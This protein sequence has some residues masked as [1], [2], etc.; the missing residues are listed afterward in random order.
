MASSQPHSRRLQILLLAAAALPPLA[1]YLI[2]FREMLPIPILDDYHAILS[3]ALDFVHLPSVAAKLAWVIHAQHNGY[4]LVFE[5]A[6]VAAQIVLLHRLDFGVLTTLGNLTLLPL[7]YALWRIYFRTESDR[8]TRLI[9]FLPV[10]CLLFAI[11]YAENLDY[12]MTS[13]QNLPVVTFAFLAVF[14]FAEPGVRR[15][16]LACLCAV[17]AVACSGNGLMLAPVVGLMLLM[18]RRVR[19]LAVA[20]VLFSALAALYLRQFQPDTTAGPSTLPGKIGYLLS[21]AGGAVENMH[22]W[23]VSGLAIAVGAVL[24]AVFLHAA[25]Q[26]FDRSEPAAFYSTLWVLITAAAVTMARAGYQIPQSLSSRYKIYSD[27]LLIFGYAYLAERLRGKLSPARRRQ[28]QAAVLAVCVIFTAAS[29]ALAY[30]FLHKRRLLTLERIEA[31]RQNPV[32]NSPQIDIL[33]PQFAQAIEDDQEYA[34]KMM[35]QAVAAGL[36]RLPPVKP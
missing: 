15:G 34:R 9:L 22:R 33:N 1:A 14:L 13:L 26:R 16:I 20:V 17:L 28:F 35:N 32:R 8:A 6:L 4:L 5:H 30:S 12:A 18:Q 11:N 3:F 23:P 2:V 10:S 19:A 27:L 36:Y 31:Y 25:A 29:D 24:V 21:F 7:L